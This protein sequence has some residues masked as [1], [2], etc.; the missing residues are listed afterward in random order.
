MNFY[1]VSNLDIKMTYIANENKSSKEWLR[2]LF[3][4]TKFFADSRVKKY[5]FFLHNEEVRQEAYLG[6]WEA[7]ITYDYQKNFDFYRWAQWNISKK[8]RDYRI[9]N[10][11]FKRAKSSIKQELGSYDFNRNLC[12]QEVRLE[13]NYLCKELVF[14]DEKLLSKK[15]KDIIIN[16]IFL[17]KKLKEI[18]SDY[19]LSIERVRQV[20]NNGLEKIRAILA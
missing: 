1:A 5:N 17:G 8:I 3:E 18:A 13:M 2:K 15:E 4:Q 16:N 11:R 10:R 14:D 12:D 6:L 20:R 7:V 19:N 9:N